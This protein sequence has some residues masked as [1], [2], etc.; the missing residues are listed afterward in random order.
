M[1]LEATQMSF[2]GLF[3]RT[4]CTENVINEEVLRRIRTS[5][6]LVLRIKKRYNEES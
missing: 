1:G 3:P 4:L 6:M 5:R 2:Y